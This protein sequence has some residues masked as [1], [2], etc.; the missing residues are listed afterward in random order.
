[1]PFLF[2]QWQKQNFPSSGPSSFSSGKLV[3]YLQQVRTIF[4]KD[5]YRVGE[6]KSERERT[7]CIEALH[8]LGLDYQLL[9]L[10]FIVMTSQLESKNRDVDNFKRC[11]SSKASC[12]IYYA[13]LFVIPVDDF[14]FRL[15]NYLK[16]DISTVSQYYIDRVLNRRKGL[17]VKRFCI[18]FCIGQRATKIENILG[19]IFKNSSI[20]EA[21][22]SH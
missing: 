11:T 3:L 17:V 15:E 19:S 12:R 20:S 22:S 2:L 14:L 21:K 10:G 13:N 5:S 6:D 4:C 8:S 16:W 7:D 18:F 9:F 1:M